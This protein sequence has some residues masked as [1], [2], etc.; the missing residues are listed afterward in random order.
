M[1]NERSPIVQDIEQLIRKASEANTII[2]AETTKF[3]SNLYKAKLKPGELATMQRKLFSDTINSFI[4]LNISYTNSLIDMGVNISKHL[5]Q[6]FSEHPDAGN[7]VTDDT[8]KPVNAPA[9]ELKTSAA[10][11]KTA[12]TA[13][14]LHSDKATAMKCEIAYSDFAGEGNNSNVLKPAVRFSPQAFELPPGSAQKVDVAVDVPANAAPGFYR[15]HIMVNG[16][17]HAYFDILLEVTA[18]Q[19]MP[20][21]KTV[22]AKKKT[23]VKKQ[24]SKNNSAKK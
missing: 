15:S 11:G 17:E 5:N 9:F 14:M 23:P 4:K 18:V 2:I 22:A 7:G 1:K 24:P 13:F 21:I 6:A 8:K 19:D 10:A 12:T 3:I 20:V 16:F